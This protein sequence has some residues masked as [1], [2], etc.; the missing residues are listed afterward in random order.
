MNHYCP[1][2]YCTS[3]DS[4]DNTTLCDSTEVEWDDENQ[5]YVTVNPCDFDYDKFTEIVSAFVHDKKCNYY[6]YAAEHFVSQS[7]FV[8]QNS[9]CANDLDTVIRLEELDDGLAELAE[10]VGKVQSCDMGDSNSASNKPGGLPSESQT[11]AIKQIPDL[12]KDIC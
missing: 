6:F 2:G 12:M 3:K 4:F 8:T 5:K 1:A 11:M 10:K 9:G 7:A